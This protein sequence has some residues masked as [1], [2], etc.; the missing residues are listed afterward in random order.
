M[1]LDLKFIFINF[2]NKKVYIEERKQGKFFGEEKEYMRVEGCDARICKR[3]MKN[4]SSL[5]KV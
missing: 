2:S 5:I 3:S 1:F 4:L